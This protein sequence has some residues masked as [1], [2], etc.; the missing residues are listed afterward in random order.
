MEL[1]KNDS[2]LSFWDRCM[3]SIIKTGHIPGHI[4]FIMDGNRRFAVKKKMQKSKGHE[5]WS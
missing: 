2:N 3:I 5:H 1:K 4:A